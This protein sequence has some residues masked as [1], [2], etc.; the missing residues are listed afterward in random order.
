LNRIST[1]WQTKI[2]YMVQVSSLIDNF[3]NNVC[4]LV[5]STQL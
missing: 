2:E 3:M 4:N 1:K 5:G